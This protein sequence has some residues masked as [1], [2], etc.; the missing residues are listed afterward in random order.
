MLTE[1]DR[2][3]LDGIATGND[4]FNNLL[5]EV[6]SVLLQP[7][8]NIRYDCEGQKIEVG[9][10]VEVVT[11]DEARKN[12]PHYEFCSK[13]KKGKVL[14]LLHGC[15]SW[16]VEV[17]FPVENMKPETVGCVDYNLRKL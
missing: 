7:N 15:N 11:E 13:G 1:K 17:K 14:R 10:D 8:H 5:T 16:F 6:A 4:R 2:K 9:N 3:A 12:N